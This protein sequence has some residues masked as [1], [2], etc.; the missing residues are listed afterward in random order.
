MILIFVL[1]VLFSA[2][3]QSTLHVSLTYF[4]WSYPSVRQ[5]AVT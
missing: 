1:G 4:S 3:V 5:A 2:S